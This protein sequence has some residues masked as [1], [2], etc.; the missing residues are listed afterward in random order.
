M[1]FPDLNKNKKNKAWLISLGLIT[2]S[3]FI[4]TLSI[5]ETQ[6]QINESSV[7]K[8]EKKPQVLGANISIQAVSGPENTSQT[9][10]LNKDSAILDTISAKAYIIFDLASGQVLL[11]KNADDKLPIASLTKLMT[12]FI[13]YKEL[14]MTDLVEFTQDFTDIKP[15]I[16]IKP[17]IKYK[18]EDLF[19]AMLVGSANDAGQALAI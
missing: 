15:V 9:L 6:K 4:F 7:V 2:L 5:I 12:G 18:V 8:I 1:N 11:S 16:G 19:R 10:V 13:A 3:V 17:G 14:S